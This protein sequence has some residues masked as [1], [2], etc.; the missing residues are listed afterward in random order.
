MTTTATGVSVVEVTGP[1]TPEFD[2][3][4]TVRQAD[5]AQLSPGDPVS[6]AEEVAAELFRTPAHMTAQAWVATQDGAPVGGA[7]RQQ[8]IDGVNDA[9]ME[10]YVMA[11][12]DHR[13]RGVALAL[14]R[15]G[16]DGLAAAGATSVIGWSTADPGAAFCRMLGLTHR[17]DDRESRL[18]IED[19]DPGQQ[20]RWIDEA[21][22]RHAGYHLDGWVGVCPDDRAAPLARAFASMVDAP[23]DDFDWDVQPVRAGELVDRERYWDARGFDV[24]TTIALAPGGEPAGATQILVSRLRPGMAHQGDTGVMA[25]HRG[26][27][28]GR[29]LKAENL[30]RA[31]AHD[32]GIATVDTMNAESNPWMLAINVDMGFRPWHSYATFQGDLEVARAAVSGSR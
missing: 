32:P 23:I 28:L 3:L 11:H 18:R 29:W 22:A 16:L 27:R 15:T 24:V 10:L 12:P 7:V 6:P 13:R 9:A 30:R 2:A 25:G 5:D 19:L 20:Q 1:G 4:V 31:L 21:P 17:Q 26:H 14:A 8:H